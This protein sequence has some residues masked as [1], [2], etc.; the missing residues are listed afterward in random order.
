[1]AKLKKTELELSHRFDRISTRH[2][3]NDELTVLHC[4]H[5]TTLYTQLADDLEFTDGKK[6]MSDVS[7]EIFYNVLDRYFKEHEIIE[8]PDKVEIAEQYYAAIGLGKMNILYVG[9]NSGEV[10]LAHSHIDEGWVKNWG[11][12]EA[13]VNFI[14]WGYI[15]AIFSL[16]NGVDNGKYKVTETE[17]LVSGGNRSLFKIAAL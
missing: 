10:E 15:S 11:N 16:F 9:G 12:R 8:L 1:M 14:T 5:Y 7:E 3:L 4:H 6:L 2:Y 13:P 17:S